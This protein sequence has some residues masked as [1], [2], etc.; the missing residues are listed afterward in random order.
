[1]ECGPVSTVTTGEQVLEFFPKGVN[2]SNCSEPIKPEDKVNIVG[3]L[4]FHMQCP[5]LTR[6]LALL[7]S[8]GP[9][10]PKAGQKLRKAMKRPAAA[11][12]GVAKKPAASAASVAAAP[13]ATA[14]AGGRIF[15]CSKCRWGKSGPHGCGQCQKWAETGAHGYKRNTDGHIFKDA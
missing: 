7:A 11:A 15:G 10:D 6:A 9:A 8:A 13:T 4:V 5:R 12:A 2:C 1:M 14:A 3:D